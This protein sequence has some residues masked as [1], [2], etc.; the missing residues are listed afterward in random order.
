ML[1]FTLSTAAD[2]NTILSL[3]SAIKF[4]GGG[5]VNHSIFWLNLSPCKS[6]PSCEL[7]RAVEK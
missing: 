4:N 1:F 3:L 6:K 7:S 5:H 2:T